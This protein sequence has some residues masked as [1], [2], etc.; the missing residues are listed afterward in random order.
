MPQIRAR[1]CP[2]VSSDLRYYEKNKHS[3]ISLHHKAV[4]T[5]TVFIK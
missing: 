4:F 5:K 1:T 3:L 2:N